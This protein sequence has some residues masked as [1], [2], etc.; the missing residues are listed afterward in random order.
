MPYDYITQDY[1]LT[2]VGQTKFLIIG[3]DSSEDQCPTPV[4]RGQCL[5]AGVSNRVF[6]L[7]GKGR[8]E[9]GELYD[10]EDWTCEPIDSMIQPRKHHISF[11]MKNSVYVTAGDDGKSF[12]LGC[13]RY[14]LNEKKWFRSHHLL[15][16]PL[17]FASVAVSAD[18][19]FAVIT[20]CM[21]PGPG[22][23][24]TIVF[25]EEI[26]FFVLSRGKC[27]DKDIVIDK[28]VIRRHKATPISLL[29]R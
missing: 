22:I 7:C 13:E 21:S 4:S 25:M 3:G 20:G 11:K 24:Q 5:F 9:E 28:S 8:T 1:T 17:V 12:L 29:I 19:T 23:G 14:D 27:V 16:Y 26:G 10:I 18:E 2:K 6:Q 15:P